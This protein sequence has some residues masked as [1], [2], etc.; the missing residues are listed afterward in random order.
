[1]SPKRNQT[2]YKQNM[3]PSPTGSDRTSTS[4]CAS[5]TGEQSPAFA[6]EVSAAVDFI[7]RHL[8]SPQSELTTAQSTAL[9]A[10]LTTLLHTL[11]SKTAWHPHAPHLGSARRCVMNTPKRMD[12]T[13]LRACTA[14]SIP[15]ALV[16][17]VLPLDLVLWIDPGS[18]SYRTGSDHSPIINI[19]EDPS[20]T[21][22]RVLQQQQIKQR[23]TQSQQ[24]HQ[25]GVSPP[26]MSGSLSQ[27][28]SPLSRGASPANGAS[29]LVYS[30]Q[31]VGG[32][33]VN[34]PVKKQ[35]V[36]KM[37]GGAGVVYVN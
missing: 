33:F 11:I 5:E 27:G 3:P 28:G 9:L 15:P 29:P 4:T 23:W 12:K 17:A 13:F 25:Q 6:A 26:L 1:M 31:F 36:M 8:S 10:S 7:G 21:Q 24:S 14:T 35:V 20:V 30:Q 18:V 37:P 16:H 2:V 32:Q 19:W 22:Q 34:L